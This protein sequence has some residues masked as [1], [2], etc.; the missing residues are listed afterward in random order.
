M[1]NRN[2]YLGASPDAVR[3]H[4]DRGTG[5]YGLWL[6]PTL[7]YSCALWTDSDSLEAAQIRKIDFH[8]ESAE[9]TGA[10]RVLDI[11]CGWGSTLERLVTRHGVTQAV[12]ITL[13]SDQANY[14][15]RK[16]TPGVEVRIENW[17]DHEPDRPYDAVV[18]VG[19]LEHCAHIDLEGDAKIAAYRRFFTKCH[20]LLDPL[21]C[22][23]LQT[24]CFGTLRQLSQF[25][26][27]RIWPESNLPVLSEIVQA[28]DGLFEIERLVSGRLDYARTC[29][30]W[31]DNLSRQ[32]AQ[33]V[34]V[35]GERV[36]SD[37]LRFLETSAR[38]FE[39]GALN[40]YRMKMRRLGP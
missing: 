10:A 11:G 35:V 26:R 16:G 22:M 18:C 39:T 6:D 13:S 30:S 32:R 20:S 36:V 29:R 17:A 25:I 24:I 27:D 19:M 40:L 1:M 31:A 33:A 14:V 3:A 9:A 4:Y 38:A 8:I 15:G 23:S 7:T 28:S 21:H 5:F 12:G 34:E 37:Y 2:S